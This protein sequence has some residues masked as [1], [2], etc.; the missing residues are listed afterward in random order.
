M[1]MV[2]FLGETPSLAL[3]KA[4]QSCG[5]EAIVVSTK[6][7]SK[8]GLDTVEMYEVIVAIEEDEVKKVV[9]SQPN[10]SRNTSPVK[11]ITKSR[12]SEEIKKILSQID[13]LQDSMSKMEA[14]IE[15]VQKSIWE[16]KSKL[17]EL[18]IPPEFSEIYSL[19]EANEFDKEMT[20]ALMNKTI[21]ELP[22]ALKNS[23]EKIKSF[24]GLILRRIVP[25]KH[26]FALEK[27]KKK[28]SILVGPTGV[29]KTT[30]IAKLAARYAFKLDENYKV[31][32]ITLDSYRIGAAE[33]LN[34]YTKIMRLPFESAD[35]IEELK[36][37]LQRLEDCSYILIDTAGSSPFDTE[38]IEKIKSYIDSINNYNVEKVLTL[39]ANLKLSDLEESYKEFNIL[40]IDQLIFTKLDETK[41]FGN[42]ISF[43]NKIQRPISYFSVGQDV[44]D[45][46][47][48]ADQKFITECFMNQKCKK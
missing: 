46:I 6:Q 43:A 37:A 35:N 25:I 3:K 18:T 21:E 1:K 12:G 42:L 39:S 14:S 15:H 11:E 47:L 40:D 48:V 9:P 16:P 36:V 30:T 13:S 19:F 4:T 20:I 41:S 32:V 10:P 2:S 31:G 23:P 26:E 38:K 44:P 29:G 24:F 5:D 22:M 7:I 17:D 33:Q 28:V 8:K 27:G 34:A 45:D